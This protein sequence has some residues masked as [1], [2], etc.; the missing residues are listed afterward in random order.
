MLTLFQE[1]YSHWCVKVRKILTYK[2]IRFESKNV[3]YHDKRELMRATGQDYVPAIVN[4]GKIVTYPDIP[5]YLERL[6]PEPSIYPSGTRE[7]AKLIENWAHYRLEEIVWRYCVSDFPKT[8][9][10]DQERWVFVEMQELKRGPLEL[11]EA[12]RQ[13]FKADMEMHFKILDEMLQGHEFL[14]TETPSLADFAVFG[15]IYPLIYSGSQVQGEY[16]RL[17]AW[18]GAIDRI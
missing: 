6:A 7:L 15:A 1:P 4:D 12:R 10:D 5:D 17:Q 9:K 14:L 16:K 11:M 18:Y 13:A 3:G 8:F 2:R